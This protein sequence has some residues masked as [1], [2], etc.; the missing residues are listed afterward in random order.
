MKNVISIYA[1]ELES[2]KSMPSLNH[3][4]LQ[5][6]L[7]VELDV[8]YRKRYTIVSELSIEMP[9]KPD[10]VPDVSIFPLLNIDFLQDQNLMNQ[11]P[12]MPLAA[13]KIISLAEL[14]YS[15]ANFERYFAAGIKSC[16]LVIS[17]LKNIYVFSDAH[18]YQ[19]FKSNEQLIDSTLEIS[20]DLKEVFR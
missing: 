10:T 9:D 16:W 14:D 18:N 1:F 13:I 8:N 12:L 3:S 6:N 15:I 2:G 4:I 17:V 5:K 20:L 19:I 11:L 7:I